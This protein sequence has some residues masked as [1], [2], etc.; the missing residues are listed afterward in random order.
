MSD[1]IKRFITCH[2]PIHACNFKCTY[3][4]IGQLEINNNK[5]YKFILPP[6]EIASKLTK[7]ALG[8]TC[9]FNL[10]G[11]GETMLHPELLDLVDG[12]TANGHFVDIITNGT[13]TKRIKDLIDRLNSKQKNHLFLKF[14]FHYLELKQKKM[15]ELFVN[16]VNGIKNAGISYTIEVTPHDELIPYIDEIKRFSLEKF[17]ALPHVTVARNESTTDIKLLTKLNR[18]EYKKI[19]G[20]FNSPLFD[21]KFAIFNRRR[22]EFC[23]AGDWSL[24]LDLKTG[25]YR[26]CYNGCIL[27]N[28]TDNNEF[29]F[30]AIGKCC[31]PH[32]FNGHAFLAFGNIPE[33]N[34][35]TYCQE[36]D[37]ITL[38]GNHWLSKECYNFFSTKAYDQNRIYSDYEKENCIKRNRNMNIKEKWIRLLNKLGKK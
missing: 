38:E 16:N 23:Y 17:G 33:L 8:G 29:H 28:I 24:E 3:C 10:C 18:L 1:G 36:R 14:S 19:W 25:E 35:P 9:Y 31:M 4:Y 15:L 20:Q 32:C 6:K 26:Q 13:I 11:N 34:T 30:R 12:L 2:V 7:E 37:R 27:G 22:N 21:F 5:T